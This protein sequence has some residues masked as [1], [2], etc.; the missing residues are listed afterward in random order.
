MSV[1]SFFERINK[2]LEA[3]QGKESKQKLYS[4]TRAYDS[5]TDA[6]LA[7]ETAKQKLFDVNGWS[8]LGILTADFTLHDAKGVPN[9]G[10][11]P[12]PGDYMLIDLPGPLPDNWVRVIDKYI[13]DTVAQFTVTPSEAPPVQATEESAPVEHFFT[14]EA[15]S[16][17]RVERRQQ[18]LMAMEIG[19]D[20]R[21]NNDADKAGDR[22]VL[23]TL[24]AAGGWTIFQK[25]Q[26][27][28]LT[29]YLIDA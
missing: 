28:A 20:E 26:W 7:F 13:D 11:E 1:A 21:V 27:K 16:T 17:F 9:A 4:S 22:S 24:I 23:N 3:L 18:Q 29:D 19:L 2:E 6:K 5:L 10:G 14:D 12:Q 8:S 15:T 25:Y